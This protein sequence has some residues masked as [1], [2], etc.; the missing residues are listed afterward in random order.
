MRWIILY[1]FPLEVYLL[2][3]LYY[4]IRVKRDKKKGFEKAGKSRYFFLTGLPLWKTVEEYEIG[5]VSTL[6]KI[7]KLSYV[8]GYTLPPP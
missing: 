2:K 3:Q 7:N 6:I 1:S 4:I 5:C 8:D